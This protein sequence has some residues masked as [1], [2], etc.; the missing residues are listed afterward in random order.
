[1]GLEGMYEAVCVRFSVEKDS[2]SHT[3]GRLGL[4]EEND[5][6]SHEAALCQMRDPKFNN[7]F[8]VQLQV[9]STLTCACATFRSY[10]TRPQNF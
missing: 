6:V 5:S 3:G 9:C 4:V 1:M 7:R 2:V 8:L 10:P